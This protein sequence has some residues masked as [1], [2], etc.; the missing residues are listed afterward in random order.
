MLITCTPNCK[1]PS[2][3]RDG[4]DAALFAPA[5]A[6]HPAVVAPA[7]ASVQCHTPQQERRHRA[8]GTH[9]PHRPSTAGLPSGPLYHPCRR[10]RRPGGSNP[11]VNGGPTAPARAV[12]LRHRP[13]LSS[14]P[15]GAPS[16]RCRDWCAPTSGRAPP[17]GLRHPGSAIRARALTSGWRGRWR[18]W[19]ARRRR[20]TSASRGQLHLRG[21]CQPMG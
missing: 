18:W 16:R 13:W 5:R 9:F 19:A 20:A 1:R 15:R 10:G 8:T 2:G 4:H 21:W 12:P 11:R 3:G 6:L 17:S 14:C 7:T